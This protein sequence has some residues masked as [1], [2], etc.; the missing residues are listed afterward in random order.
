MNR[1]WKDEN[2]FLKLISRGEKECGLF[3]EWSVLNGRRHMGVGNGDPEG[4]GASACKAWSATWRGTDKM[5]TLF[6]QRYC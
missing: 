3:R 2:S 4:L 5:W 1:A 6:Q